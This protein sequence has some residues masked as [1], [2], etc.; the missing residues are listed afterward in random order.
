MIKKV[1]LVVLCWSLAGCAGAADYEI[2]LENGY[3]ID[4]LSA[5]QIAIYGDEPVKSDDETF[6]N[7]LYVP[8]K[9]SSVKE[10][11]V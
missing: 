7:Y 3:R 1:V 8:A 5:H 2:D 4:R 9:V 11:Y 6:Y 10:D